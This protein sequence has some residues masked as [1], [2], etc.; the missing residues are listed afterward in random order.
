MSFFDNNDLIKYQF[1]NKN[2][3]N[4][5][6]ALATIGGSVAQAQAQETADV[7]QTTKAPNNTANTSPIQ[8]DGTPV[9]DVSKLNPL[10]KATVYGDEY[11]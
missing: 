5:A 4:I 3:L 2:I 6:I 9:D 7:L 8:L 11:M 1:I 10:P